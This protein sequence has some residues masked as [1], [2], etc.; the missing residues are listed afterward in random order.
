MDQESLV[1]EE[2]DA[3][4]EL[5]R[6]LDKYV[7][8]KV[9]YWVKLSEEGQWYLYIASEQINDQ[10]L[11]M[12]YGEVLRLADEMAS[13]YLDPFRVKLIPTSDPLAQAALDVHRRYPGPMAT[14]FG[15]KDF[16]GLAVDGVYIYPAC[17]TTLAP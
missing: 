14:R 1:V 13:A 5:V 6:R 7:P 4:A 17:V 12:H 2:T 3:G 11:D 15:G 9:A 10:N 8:V 16:G